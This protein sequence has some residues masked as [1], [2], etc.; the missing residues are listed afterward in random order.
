MLS[1]SGNKWL[2][3]VNACCLLR[4]EFTVTFDLL[5][6]KLVFSIIGGGFD[7]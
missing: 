7:K 3:R 5:V 4:K 1:N 6:P 2:L